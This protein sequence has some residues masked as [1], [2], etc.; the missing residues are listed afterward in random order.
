[1]GGLLGGLMRLIATGVGFLLILAVIAVFVFGQ[2]PEP[3][4]PHICSDPNS[5]AAQKVRANM[6]PDFET[7]AELDHYVAKQRCDRAHKLKVTYR[8]AG[9]AHEPLPDTLAEC[10]LARMPRP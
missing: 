1:M 4:P 6:I 3:C 10:D 2:K 7:K 9:I 5:L 8:E